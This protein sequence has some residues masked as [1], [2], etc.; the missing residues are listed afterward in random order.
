MTSRVLYPQSIPTMSPPPSTSVIA[1]SQALRHAR[2]PGI[3]DLPRQLS[4]RILN[5]L[6]LE[7]LRAFSASSRNLYTLA[8]AAGLYIPQE[9]LWTSRSG[10]GGSLVTLNDILDHAQNVRPE[11]RLAVSVSF[12]SSRRPVPVAAVQPLF[13]SLA[14]ALPF[15]VRL[16]LSLPAG[17]PA[18]AVSALLSSHGAPYLRTFILQL[19]AG[20]IPSNLFNRHAPML[21]NLSL[22][23][24][25]R[26]KLAA[27]APVLALRNVTRLLLVLEG[28]AQNLR[29]A[30]HFPALRVLWI[31]SSG[32]PQTTTIDV[33]GL[34]LDRLALKG[35]S[36][37][38]TDTSGIRVVEHYSDRILAFW[39]SGCDE[40][41]ARAECAIGS[42]PKLS[43]TPRGGAWRRT[44]AMTQK[45]DCG[46]ALPLA[47]APILARSLVS[48]TLDKT[49]VN[50]LVQTPVELRA[51]CELL[52][53]V[54]AEDGV[55]VWPPTSPD[56]LGLRVDFADLA[57]R[58][59]CPALAHIVVFTT[60]GTQPV[61]VRPNKVTRL[62]RALGAQDQ[63]A[64]LT[65]AGC[66]F[67]SPPVW[68]AFE[69]VFSGV[70]VVGHA[71]AYIPAY[72]EA[73]KYSGVFGESGWFI[74]KDI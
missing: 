45:S 53:D 14:R 4:L 26:A 16:D 35:D 7:D 21:R 63:Q 40:I 25:D 1:P 37:V 56:Q 68:S 6:E 67:F 30:D 52:L 10:Y 15:L 73:C 55:Q 38:L 64:A 57:P 24:P 32:G 47:D 27:L 51:L 48:L 17:A 44:V 5:H 70:S 39:P 2:A 18:S 8:C 19:A 41:Y 54:T 60:P 69:K 46:A 13:A 22:N 36:V 9:V 61:A 11:L 62:A 74:R 65:I 12:M 23:M 31:Q 50:A 33:A 72:Y 59:R 49:L 28:P 71:G 58:V 3:Y 66:T 34:R 42:Q 43:F 20:G 29:I